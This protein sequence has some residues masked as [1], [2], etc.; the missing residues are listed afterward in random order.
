MVIKSDTKL[1]C[2]LGHPVKHSKSPLMQNKA[3]EI[4]GEDAVYLVF[5]VLPEKLKES[6]EGIKAMGFKG[7]NVTIPHKE[8]VM[9]YLDELTK[10]AENIG[11]VN[12]IVAKDGKL[13]GDNTDGQGFVLSLMNE[14]GFDP[15][16]KKVLMLGAGGAAKAVAV[17]LS[18]EGIKSMA[19][20]EIDK[21]KADKLR[22]HIKAINKES[23]IEVI[24]KNELENRASVADLIVNCTPVGMKDSDPEL[25]SESVFFEGQFVFDLIY[26]PEKTKL[27]QNA[28]KKGAK[29]LNG[30]G[31]LVFQGAL[32]FEKWT[33]KKP[34]TKAMFKA[35]KG[36]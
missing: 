34:D 10:E 7:A 12:T 33:G 15:R 23:E 9:K 30:L 13:I 2:L 35:I 4:A 16:D 14:G 17:K 29:I 18:F 5:D 19:I 1:I 32:A 21:E 36:E 6:I 24:S 28:E 31:M 8:E 27:L 25:L 3:L 11:A 26:N 22:E 20:Y